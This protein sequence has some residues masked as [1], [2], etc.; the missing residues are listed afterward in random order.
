MQVEDLHHVMGFFL[1]SKKSFQFF[2]RLHGSQ[3]SVFKYDDKKWSQKMLV[4][5]NGVSIWESG[6]MGLVFPK[7]CY[8][9]VTKA[10]SY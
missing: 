7:W 3:I 1:L 10:A 6:F 8:L 2:N 5:L 4:G 9:L